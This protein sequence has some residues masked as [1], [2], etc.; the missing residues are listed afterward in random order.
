MTETGALLVDGTWALPSRTEP[1]DP[2]LKDTF[3]SVDTDAIKAAPITERLSAS[4]DAFGKAG[5]DGTK[6][7]AVYDR[8]GLFSAPWIMWLLR[9]HGC[10]AQLVE[11]WGETQ[12][13]SQL[14]PPTRFLPSR[15]PSEMNVSRDNVLAAIGTDVQIV[16]ARPPGRFAG[17]SPEPRPGCRAG[18]IPGSLDV[19]FGTLK[20]GRSFHNVST[21]SSLF[22]DA[23]VDLAKPVITTCGS[24]VTASGLAVALTRCGA[25]DV[26]VY[27]GSWAEW[28]MDDTLPIE[29]GA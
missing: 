2:Y 13:A 21:L 19:P 26:K 15:D 18:H 5:L 3:A 24:G 10:E 9:S 4:V 16:D 27:Q 20:D 7:V 14:A 25:A 17:A 1:F 12:L 8:V 6:P 29:T 11:G 23:G 22:Q 28:G